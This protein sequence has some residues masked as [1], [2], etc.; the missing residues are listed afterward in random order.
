MK[1][2]NKKKVNVGK[3]RNTS[4]R[5]ELQKAEDSQ[6]MEEKRRDLFRRFIPVNR[7]PFLARGS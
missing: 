4:I 6:K 5:E 7:A 1:K 2:P 3:N